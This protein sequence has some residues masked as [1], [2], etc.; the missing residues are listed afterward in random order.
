MEKSK[1]LSEY[2][3]FKAHYQDFVDS[4]V[5]HDDNKSSEAK[6]SSDATTGSYGMMTIRTKELRV[7]KVKL[8]N[9]G[10]EVGV[11]ID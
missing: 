2:Q 1:L 8:G 6:Q 5:I 11:E 7:L 9:R 4:I 3:S 10:W